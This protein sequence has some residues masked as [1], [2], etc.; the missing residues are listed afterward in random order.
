M[1]ACGNPERR[2]GMKGRL[3]MLAAV[4]A[5]S[6]AVALGTVVPAEASG[7]TGN[8]PF[9]EEFFIERCTFSTS[10]SNPYY[11]LEPGMELVLAGEEDKAYVE[12]IITVLEETMEVD[13]VETRVVREYETEDGEL[14]EVSWNY[15]AIC[16]QTSDVYYFG[17]DV[18]DYEDGV[19]VGHEGAWRAGVDGAQAG[20]F[21]PGTPMIGA[22][23]FQEIAPD[24]AMDRAEILTLNYT[25]VTPAGVFP[26]S[27][28]V[29]ETTPLEPYAKDIKVH[30]RDLGLVRDGPLFL[31]DYALP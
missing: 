15:F 29:M 20:V 9:T 19:I 16:D 31:V 3:G 18:D 24:V 22:R 30:A 28:V 12:V 21:M 1:A 23:H 27:Q 6:V 13:G 5:L 11:I 26:G 8:R 2:N 17:E 10:G 14:V 4:L 7:G 25:A